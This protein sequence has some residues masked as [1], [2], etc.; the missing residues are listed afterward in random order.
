[1]QRGTPIPFGRMLK[2]VKVP[3]MSGIPSS[4]F[5]CQQQVNVRLIYSRSIA[6]LVIATY[7]F[8]SRSLIPD[9]I[10][11]PFL[12]RAFVS[13]S[14]IFGRNGYLSD[15]ETMVSFK[16]AVFLEYIIKFNMKKYISYVNITTLY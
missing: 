10:H 11:L 8:H 16:R 7:M 12:T 13:E 15:M 5:R 6:K 3:P 4:S 2:H 1:L 9:G 14:V